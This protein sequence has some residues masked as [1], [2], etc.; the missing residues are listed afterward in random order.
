[1]GV[2]LLITMVVL[3]V[4]IAG[5]GHFGIVI[6]PR[7]PNA[8]F[9]CSDLRQLCQEIRPLLESALDGA[10]HRFRKR[11]GR[12]YVG[13]PSDLA[14]YGWSNSKSLGELTMRTPLEAM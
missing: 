7:S 6:R 5:K 12:R 10:L 2:V 14:W 9:G 1:A 11:S 3:V 13:K 4:Q 8:R